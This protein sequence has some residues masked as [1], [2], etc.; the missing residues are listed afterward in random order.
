MVWG[1]EVAVNDLRAFRWTGAF[2]E[3]KESFQGARLSEVGDSISHF[4]PL[5][6]TPF[7]PVPA[8]RQ[9]GT[10]RGFQVWS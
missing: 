7:I 4:L 3:K 5:A 9:A 6:D 8:Y 1:K 10:G 2:R